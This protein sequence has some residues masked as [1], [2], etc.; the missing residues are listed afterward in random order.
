MEEIEKM[1]LALIE[2]YAYGYITDDECVE[3]CDL[4]CNTFTTFKS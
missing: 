1:V 3:M 4:Y 2:A